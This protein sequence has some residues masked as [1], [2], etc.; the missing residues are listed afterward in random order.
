MDFIDLKL[1]KLMTKNE[2]KLYCKKYNIAL[3]KKIFFDDVKMYVYKTS[4]ELSNDIYMYE[5][6]NHIRNGLYF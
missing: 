1:N 2:Y 4:Y 5:L 3:M 6:N